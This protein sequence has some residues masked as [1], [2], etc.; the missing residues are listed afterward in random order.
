MSYKVS[1][2]LTRFNNVTW[3]EKPLL[4]DRFINDS[5]IPEACVMTFSSEAT[6]RQERDAAN[7]LF[8]GV[9]VF[10]VVKVHSA[11]SSWPGAPPFSCVKCSEK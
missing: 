7:R 5:R 3:V 8:T 9:G 10:I 11:D 6:V 2:S 1:F 4:S